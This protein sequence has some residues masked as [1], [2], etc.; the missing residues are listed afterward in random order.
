VLA[1]GLGRAVYIWSACTS[2]VT[3]LC[4]VPVDDSITSV[5]WS[6]RGSHLAVGTNS[7]DTQI[8]DTSHCK[9]VRTLSG[10]LSRVGT[11]A[12][13]GSIVSTGSRDRNIFQRD[14]RA[15][16]QFFQKLSG[17]KQE[18]CG[19]RWSFDETQ[20]ASGGNDNKLMVWSL[21]NGE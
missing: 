21:Q 5:G 11:V 20:L 9:L 1:V 15:Q 3:K 4:E 14:L 19:L 16:N 13:N 2:R 6:Q 8:W 17:H 10:H 18:V 12:W 7:G